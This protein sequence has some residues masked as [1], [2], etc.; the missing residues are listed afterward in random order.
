VKKN[1]LNFWKNRPIRFG[2]GFI[3]LKPKKPNR[4][5]PKQKKSSQTGKNWA[6]TSQTGKNRVKP[7]WTGFC[8]KKP[9]RTETD[10]F[11]P[12]SV[13]FLNSIWLFLFDK[14]QTEP[15]I[16]H[17]WLSRITYYLY[18]SDHCLI[19]EKNHCQYCRCLIGVIK[20]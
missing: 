7:V 13:F 19:E 14:N 5:K 8:S 6:K 10:R 1:R 17:I 16:T 15:K 18:H 20:S 12:V 2:F 3:S 4:T 9:N 11:E